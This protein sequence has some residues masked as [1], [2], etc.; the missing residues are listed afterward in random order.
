M[1]NRH[2]SHD[3]GSRSKK[4]KSDEVEIRLLKALKADDK[5]NRHLS[6]F[7]AVMPTLEKFDENEVLKFQIGVLQL[8]LQINDEK[9]RVSLPLFP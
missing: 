6:F 1:N 2:A 3:F 4:R 8:I 5:P 9:Q 7:H